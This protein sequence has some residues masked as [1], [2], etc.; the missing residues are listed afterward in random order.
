[1]TCLS[2]EHNLVIYLMTIAAR[3]IQLLLNSKPE[4]HQ[5]YLILSNVIDITQ[6][7][8]LI[9]S[10]LINIFATSIIA[11]KA[12]CVHSMVSLDNIC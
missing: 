11:L 2:L 12:W 6:V 1:M 9:F 3:A 4:V 7:A 8:H 10:V 5:I